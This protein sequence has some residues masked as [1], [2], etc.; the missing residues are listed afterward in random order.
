MQAREAK[1]QK[2]L[3][4]LHADYEDAVQ[5]KKNLYLNYCLAMLPP[6]HVKDPFVAEI[7]S[8]TLMN[9][10]GNLQIFRKDLLLK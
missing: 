1:C 6:E 8:N 7:Y 5:E 10:T 3:A 2:N 9:F 4:K